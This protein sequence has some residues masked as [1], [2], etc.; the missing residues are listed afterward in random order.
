MT[1]LTLLRRLKTRLH[2]SLFD[3]PADDEMGVLDDMWDGQK[4]DL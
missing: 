2:R 4:D 3:D 1:S